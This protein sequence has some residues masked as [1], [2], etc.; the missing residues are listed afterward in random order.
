M[1]NIRDRTVTTNRSATCQPT[2]P[3]QAQSQ[4]T[5]LKP[6]GSAQS[7]PTEPSQGGSVTGHTSVYQR[8]STLH[9]VEH[10]CSKGRSPS[11]HPCLSVGTTVGQWALRL[12]S[13][14]HGRALLTRVTA[15]VL[16]YG[17][18]KMKHQQ[19]SQKGTVCAQASLSLSDRTGEQSGISQLDK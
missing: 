10:L 6:R 5:E 14:H 8:C 16:K 15:K 17:N 12:V 19:H 18:G 13:G 7:K 11:N 3:S 1:D 4:P 2:E 9:L